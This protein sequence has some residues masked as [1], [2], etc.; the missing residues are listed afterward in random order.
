MVVGPA[1]DIVTLGRS[2]VDLYGDQVGGRLEDVLSFSKYVGGCPS[3][4][5][6]GTARLGLR[7]GIITRVGEDH[8]GRFIREQFEREGVDTRG[9][10]SDPQRLTSLV[11]LGLR[12]RD[13]FPLIFYRENCADSALD[14]D[15]ID[16]DFVATSRSLLITGTHLSR[17]GLYA[18]SAKAVE[19]A[20]GAGAKIIL[21][22]DYRPVLWGLTRPDLG[23]NRFVSSDAV[24]QQMQSLVPACDLIVGTEE[25][26]H[27]LG[28]V[29]DTLAALKAARE[30]TD[31]LLVLKT[32][33]KGCIAFEGA[34]PERL[35][36]GLVVGGFPT[37]VFNVLGAGDAFFSGFLAGWLR[38]KPLAECCRMGNAAGA[39]VVSRH[40]CSP[41]SPTAQELE[42]FLAGQAKGP[43]LRKDQALEQ[44]HWS[45][46]RPSRDGDVMVLAIDHRSQL[47]Q[48]AA[49]EGA[50]CA[51]IPAIKTLALRAVERL[52]R[53][54]GQLGILLDGR[55]GE[56]ALAQ[57][58]GTGMWIG[59][60]IELPGSCPLEFDTDIADVTSELRLW[61][62][63]HIVKCLC[64]YHPDDPEDLRAEQERQLLRLASACRNTGHEFL[65]EII[66]S[67]RGAVDANTAAS[68][69]ERIYDLGIYP[70]WWK[71]EPSEDPACWARINA[72][73]EHRDPYCQ[74]IVLLGLSAPEERLIASFEVATRV[75]TMRGFAVGRTIFAD[76][77]RLW[78]ANLISDGQAED[79]LYQ[80][81]RRLVIGWKRAR[82]SA[83]VAA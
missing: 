44:L 24:T 83:K 52:H 4:I 9:V 26:F 38:D 18:A 61:P 43:A 53:E 30:L 32:G 41:A 55:Y 74:G 47:E 77:A 8:M 22:I 66:A 58:S 16:P 75:P 60:P 31:A 1:L 46:T 49:E 5:A 12:D 23:E 63:D 64:F 13:T 57:A 62:R 80:N 33:A 42:W 71:L 69:I 70:D 65:L 11:L 10:A 56:A 82:Q 59:R 7:S 34:I 29:E 20:N 6:I 36:E 28:G 54:E 19:I 45:T 17:P 37:E 14:V 81:F 35:M 78:L 68:I 3:N 76:P 72:A 40:G 39:L 2:S 79:M 27:I 50:D 21:D 25:E 67:H 48:I 73:I 15:D 51:R